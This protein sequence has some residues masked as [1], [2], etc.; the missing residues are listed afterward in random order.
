MR[1]NHIPGAAMAVV[2]DG[3]LFLAKGYGYADL[4]RGTRVSP[5]ATV[6]RTG[7]ISKVLTWTAVMQLVEQGKLDLN[8]DINRYLSHFQIPA[9]FDQPITLAHLMTHTAGFE[10]QIS[11][12]T[13]YAA[14]DTYRPL[15]EFLADNVPARIFPP[16]QVV[17]YSN[18][19]AALAGEIVAEVSG[20]TFDEYIA[21]H[22]FEPLAMG[23][24]T[25]RQPLPPGL[26]QAAAVSYAADENGQPQAGAF[27]YVQVQP[28]G[29]LSAAAT[30]IAN[31]MIAH[32]QDGRFG[33]GH[34]LQPE[35][36]Q[37]MRRQYYAFH[38]R[39]PGL[40]RGFAEVYRNGIRLVIHPGTTDRSASLLA[41]L[42]DQDVGIFVTFNSYVSTAP[43]LALLHELLDHYFPEPGGPAV[44][45]PA[46]FAD[47]SAS[48]AGNYL[49]SRRAET[50]LDALAAPLQEVSVRSNPDGTLTVAAFQGSDGQPIR[51]VEVAPQVFQEAGGQ[52]MLAFQLDAHGQVTG[53]FY[54]DQPIH[55][56]H[57]LAWYQDPQV[58]LAGLGL[59]LLVFVVTLA[60]WILGALLRVGGR[61]MA[62]R[63][64]ERWA[65]LLAVG[66]I[67]LNLVIVGLVV[68]V[69]A[70]DDAALQFSYPTGFAIAGALSLVSG[71]VTVLLLALTAGAWRQQAWGIGK[72]VHYSLVTAAAVY[73]FWYLAHINLLALRF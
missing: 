48:F 30:D 46:D 61:R 7:S 21:S 14:A 63:P 25:F 54:G 29:A 47:H 51:W 40:T 37:D 19:G 68:S 45:A 12:G 9:T 22:I 57:R 1:I 73:F 50:T 64:L 41:L 34:I 44:G 5:S 32:L 70:G 60:I 62:A 17:A 66:L 59:A 3:L 33:D 13:L 56:F 35:S 58:R 10:D 24:S 71:L 69:L 27:E 15:R 65:R 16:G 39:L 31:L 38:P 26:A 18:Y 20:E 36:A 42:P 8:A 2:K 67:L 72:R 49:S 6:F 52:G 28:A 11:A 23:H 55:E 4:A 43:R 53:M